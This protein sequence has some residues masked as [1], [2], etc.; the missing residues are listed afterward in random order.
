M[1]REIDE[2]DCQHG[3]ADTEDEYSKS[4]AIYEGTKKQ[5]K[6][7]Y[8]NF[9]DSE[10]EKLVGPRLAMVLQHLTSSK[11]ADRDYAKNHIRNLVRLAK[12]V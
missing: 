6:K 5:I 11:K 2:R 9:D 3:Q 4:D 1:P 10:I 12:D 8:P 7:D